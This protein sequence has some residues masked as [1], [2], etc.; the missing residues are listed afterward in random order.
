MIDRETW[1]I[2]AE[3]LEQTRRAREEAEQPEVRLEFDA[4][5]QARV[6]PV[7]R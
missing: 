4:H 3:R 1:I 7:E 6:V 5:D 2:L